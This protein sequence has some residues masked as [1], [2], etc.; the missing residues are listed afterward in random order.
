M[1]MQIKA[2]QMIGGLE[3]RTLRDLLRKSP[4]GFN[5]NWL[6]QELAIGKQSSTQVLRALQAEGYVEADLGRARRPDTWFKITD[7]G[8]RLIRA[9]AA[10]PVK[11]STARQAVASLM[12]RI[13]A[14]NRNP[15]YL[16]SITKAVV[17]GSFLT[18]TDRLGDVDVAIEIVP[19]IPLKG[20]WAQEFLEHARS[21]GRR[22]DSFDAELDWPRREVL[23]ALKAKKR[24]ISV[25]SWFSFTQMEKARDFRY[26]VLLGDPEEIR[27]DLEQAAR[28]NLNTRGKT[29]SADSGSAYR[30]SNPWGAAKSSTWPCHLSEAVFSGNL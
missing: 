3:A 6:K 29:G 16:Y 24:S 27:R 19:R 21:S 7:L 23:L 26:E 4:G 2:G 14:I 1:T 11:R 5:Q 15:Q 28:E 12:Q 13:E 17:F 8:R 18:D 22:F 25:H 30:G 10:E 20:K 9:S